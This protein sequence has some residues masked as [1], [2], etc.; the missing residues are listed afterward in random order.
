[1][2]ITINSDS[3]YSTQQVAILLGKSENEVRKMVR[4]GEL[5]KGRSMSKQGY[6]LIE[7]NALN[8]YFYRKTGNWRHIDI[9]LPDNLV[10]RYLYETRKKCSREIT[11]AANAIRRENLEL[12]KLL[13]EEES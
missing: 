5:E 10:D 4:T 6:Y 9:E 7:G 8:W 11:A 3:N 13:L 2:K 12:S 1:M